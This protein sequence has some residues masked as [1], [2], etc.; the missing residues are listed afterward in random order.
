[1]KNHSVQ[2]KKIIMIIF[3][4][5]ITFFISNSNAQIVKVSRVSEIAKYTSQ[6]YGKNTLVLFDVDYVL[7]VPKDK[8]LRPAGEENNYRS[9]SFKAINKN[10]HE[11]NIIYGKNKIA[12]DEYLISQILYSTKVELVSLDMPVFF[13]ELESQKMTIV[14]LTSNSSGR[15]GVVQNEAELHL[16]RLKTLGYNFK[17]NNDLLKVDLPECVSGVIFTNKKDKGKVLLNFLKQLNKNYKN[18]VFVDDRMKNLISVQNALKNHRINYI[19][20]NYTELKDRNEVI[21]QDIANKQFEVLSQEHIW[22]S[23][24]E[25]QD[26]L[27]NISK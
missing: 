19:G 16:S 15:Y 18:I 8:V 3:M 24:T 9:K 5:F 2:T 13:E 7:L 10:F 26:R 25:A 11:K 12:M 27:N 22:L 21:D 20:I 14:G 6:L 4:I 1:M 17:N 23:D